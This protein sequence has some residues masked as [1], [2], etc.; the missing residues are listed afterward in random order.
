MVGVVQT[1]AVMQGHALASV[2]E[3]YGVHIGVLCLSENKFTGFRGTDTGHR[4]FN[5]THMA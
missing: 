3:E 4:L 5:T 2:M 1:D